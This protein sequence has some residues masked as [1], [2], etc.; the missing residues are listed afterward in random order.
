MVPNLHGHY[1]CG[2]SG[3]HN[4]AI[5]TKYLNDSMP[6]NENICRGSNHV[7]HCIKRQGAIINK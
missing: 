6:W 7:P 2:V 4:C 1:L 5:C 3:Q